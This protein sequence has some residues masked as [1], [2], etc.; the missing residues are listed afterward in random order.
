MP[1][2]EDYQDVNY[3]PALASGNLFA[4]PPVSPVEDI[5]AG[6]FGTLTAEPA[7]NQNVQGYGA[8]A[9]GKWRV[10]FSRDL[11]SPEAEDASFTTGKVYSIAF[12]AWDGANGERNGQKST[13][14]WISLQ[15]EQQGKAPAAAQGEQQGAQAGLPVQPITWAILGVAL[16]LVLAGAVI[17]MRLP[18]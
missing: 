15:L 16:V 1:S 14:Q 9:D 6:G 7:S 11:T 4:A 17:Y 12:A 18:E 2:P 13:S 3:V 8:W 5:V 10:I